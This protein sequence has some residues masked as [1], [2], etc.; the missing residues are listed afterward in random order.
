MSLHTVMQGIRTSECEWLLPV[1][2]TSGKL[3]LLRHTPAETHK[4]D[5]LMREFIFWY[6]DQFLVPL[7]RVSK[8]KKV[9]FGFMLMVVLPRPHFT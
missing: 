9:V 3:K 1:S 8:E 4:R 5:E 7:L 6:F 2:L